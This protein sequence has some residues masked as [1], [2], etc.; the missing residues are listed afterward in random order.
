MIRSILNGQRG[1]VATLISIGFLAFSIPLIS[2]SL[3]LAEATSIDA[4]VKTEKLS[5][6]YCSLAVVELFN[7]LVGDIS[8]FDAW[9]L[10]HDPNGTGTATASLGLENIDCGISVGAQEPMVTD[11]PVGD[12]VGVVPMLGSYQ[13]RKF[14]TFVTVDNPNPNPG[15][16]VLYTIELVNRVANQASLTDIRDTLPA[17]FSYDCL[18]PPNRT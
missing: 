8:R 4:R 7:Y 6:E 10:E 16:S 3:G 14:Q 18:G 1:G 2:G 17:A 12:P 15:E 5:Q 13:Q 11:D 9:M